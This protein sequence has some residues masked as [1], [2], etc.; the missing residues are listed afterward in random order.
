LVPSGRGELMRYWF[1]ENA[2]TLDLED[3]R[4]CHDK[5]DSRPASPRSE[6]RIEKVSRQNSEAQNS[7]AKDTKE[8]LASS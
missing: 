1:G 3:S 4:F 2:T 7:L 5:L 6:G 8:I